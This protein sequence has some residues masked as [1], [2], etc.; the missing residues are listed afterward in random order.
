MLISRSPVVF[1]SALV[2]VCRAAIVCRAEERLQLATSTSQVPEG[3][4][5]ESLIFEER[6]RTTDLLIFPCWGMP[7]AK[8][9][10]LSETMFA[11]A[12]FGEDDPS[13]VAVFRQS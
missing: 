9:L 8:R 3:V 4:C 5:S 2:L 13:E 7:L 11:I 10:F 12:W 1:R 6:R